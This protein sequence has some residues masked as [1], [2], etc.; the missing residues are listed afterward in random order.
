LDFSSEDTQLNVSFSGDYSTL[1]S[2][3]PFH[4][5]SGD[6]I[7]LKIDKTLPDDTDPD[8]NPL[9]AECEFTIHAG[10]TTLSMST[11]SQSFV[12]FDEPNGSTDKYS[13]FNVSITD[14]GNTAPTVSSLTVNLNGSFTPGNYFEV[15]ANGA[16]TASNGK[17][18]IPCR[19]KFKDSV[20]FNDL[21]FITAEQPVT[22]AVR[23]AC[24]YG[25]GYST[26]TTP[27][28]SQ[29]VN[30]QPV[31]GVTF[32]S[33]SSEVIGYMNDVE[34]PS[35]ATLNYG[36]LGFTTPAD[37]RPQYSTNGVS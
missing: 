36:V 11:L 2:T 12:N 6:S 17:I 25:S 19:F 22:V 13:D 32:N 5:N 15:V 7:E 34:I 33:F 1:L 23:Y 16:P 35:T 27:S 20:G 24:T 21:T 31:A 4:I 18:T 29:T 30:Y 10:Y 26:Y 3:D 14:Y 28:T 9:H 8:G 37:V